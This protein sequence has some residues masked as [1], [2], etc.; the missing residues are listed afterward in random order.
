[1]A[2]GGPEAAVPGAATAPSAPAV[3]Q[4]PT[5]AF[6][7]AAFAGDPGLCHIGAYA[8]E[9]GAQ[10]VITPSDGP[11]LRYRYLDGRSGK[12]FPVDGQAYESSEGWS[13]HTPVTLRARFGT[14]SERRIELESGGRTVRGLRIDLPMQPVNFA[15]GT[16]ML[17]GELVMPTGGPPRAAVVLQY[18]SGRDSAVV[19]NFL[20]YLLPLKGIAVFVFDKRGTGRSQGEYTA[21]IEVLAEDLAA[22]VAA[23][24]PRAELRDVPLGIMSESQGGWVAP[25][26]AT[27]VDVDFVVVS[28]GLAI[29][30]LEEDRE[31]VI[32]SLSLKGYGPEILAKA[33]QVHRATSRIMVTRFAAG[34]D[35]LAKLQARYAHEPW[36][37]E[38]GGDFTGPLSAAPAE[39]MTEMRALFDFPYD[40][41]YDPLPV[42]R[43]LNVPMLWVLAGEDT[44]APHESTLRRLRQ[45][46]CDGSKID[47][48][49][50]PHADHGMIA[51]ERRSGEPV[52]AG[53]HAPGYFD[54]LE[55]WMVSRTLDG[56]YGQAI[57][58]ASAIRSSCCRRG[59][60]TAPEM[61]GQPRD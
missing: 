50:F 31:E 32:Q 60:L 20:Q 5:A 21:V 36:F 37:R 44:E 59:R 26:A 58:F 57:L 30:M 9:D 61:A 14:C 43:S 35:E 55:E 33:E 17:Y 54:L 3:L 10:V 42:I 12:L 53:R 52:L 24:R 11:N 25:L 15:S 1:M 16:Q 29:S 23:V 2:A 18:G 6:E 51:V 46:Q 4:P 34:L 8:T 27:K 28:Y 13:A 38:L 48:A 19:Y 47:V 41:T 45:L 49:V 40:L 7:A 22:A 39:R 56:A